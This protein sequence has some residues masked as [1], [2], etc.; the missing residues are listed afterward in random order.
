[1]KK[2]SKIA[3]AKKKP[4]AKKTIKKQ[5][6]PARNF[7]KTSAGISFVIFVLM[8]VLW[9]GI[10]YYMLSNKTS[11]KQAPII[12]KSNITKEN[13]QKTNQS[14]Q[15]LVRD[16]RLDEALE[17]LSQQAK[18]Q[19]Q[20]LQINTKIKAKSAKL[21]IIMDDISL[22]SQVDE[23]K[24][25]KIKITPSIFPPFKSREHTNLLADEFKTYMVHLP[26]A[27]YNY[28]DTTGALSQNA[29]PTQIKKKITEI[30]KQFKNLQYINNHTGSAFT[31][32]YKA[33][34]ILLKELK[35]QGIKFVDSKTTPNSAVPKAS[36]E[37][38]LSYVYRD[39]FLDNEQNEK[40][41]LHQLQLAI[42]IAKKE[43]HAIAICHP[44][45]AT[46]KA[47]KK[48]QDNILKDIE[49]VYLDEIYGLY[50]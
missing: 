36:Q 47:L 39:V 46:F 42:K 16:T 22:K 15:N 12:A 9:L 50:N 28:K 19:T 14:T 35:A 44:Y 43:G 25:L 26:L 29:T 24:S 32:N 6:K 17:K 34:K 10:V 21:A 5:T 48:A 20:N 4:V 23:I 2:S 41:I 31:Q 45:P 11:S 3:T 40:S 27:A 18:T 37:L 30:K 7:T 33:T 1:M 8:A 13:I 38:G 49:I